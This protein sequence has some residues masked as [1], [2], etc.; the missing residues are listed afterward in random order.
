MRSFIKKLFFK[1]AGIKTFYITRLL[2]N[3]IEEKVV[4]KNERAAI[5]ISKS[6]GMICLDPFCVAIWL[7]TEHTGSINIEKT[8]IQ[9]TKGDKVNASIKL[10]LIE[11]IATS[12]GALLLYKVEKVRNHQ[13]TALHRL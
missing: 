12:S 6:H 11:K 4:L 3:Q 9:F 2:Q 13:F 7:S 5:D 1:D 10:G 8:E